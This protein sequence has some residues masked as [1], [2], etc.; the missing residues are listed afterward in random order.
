MNFHVYTDGACKGNPGKG[1]YAY[2]V[3]DDMNEIWIKSSG[4]EIDTT[5][6]R[7]ELVAVIEALHMINKTYQNYTIKVYSDSAYIVNCFNDNWIGKWKENGWKTSKKEAVVN[8][9]LW[10][11]LDELVIKT[12]AKF[13]RILRK[14]P[15]MHQ[16]D[17]DARLASKN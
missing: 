15:R 9:E 13:E 8:Q 1:G 3:Y 2:I 4:S 7:M 10:K 11:I 16:V 12:N 17:K 5:N 6:N 14:D